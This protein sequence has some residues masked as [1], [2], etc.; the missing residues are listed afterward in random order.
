MGLTGCS[1]LCN[2][3]GSHRR[4]WTLQKVKREKKN[5]RNKIDADFNDCCC[6]NAVIETIES[7]LEPIR[8]KVRWCPNMDADM[9]CEYR[10]WKSIERRIMCSSIWFCFL[11]FFFVFF[12]KLN[13]S[14]HN[15]ELQPKD[16]RRTHLQPRTKMGTHF[17]LCADL[18]RR[19]NQAINVYINHILDTWPAR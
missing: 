19:L 1:F 10:N 8:W 18:L 4:W 16:V 14:L 9:R 13:G 7:T 6:C 12:P 15:G 5:A 2:C 17:D 3:S 11:C